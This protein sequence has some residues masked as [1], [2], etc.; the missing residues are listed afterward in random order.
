MQKLKNLVKKYFK[1][2]SFFYRYLRGK[3]FIAFILSVGVSFLDGLGLTMFIPLLQIVEDGGMANPDEMGQLGIFVKVIQGLGIPMT[4][5]GVLVIMIVFFSLKGV[6]T[7]LRS[8]Y[9]VILLQ[10]FNRKIRLNLLNL[11]N[12]LD[13]KRFILSDVGRIQNTMT[14]EV[15]R[16]ASAFANYFRTF[17][18][19]VM[20]LVYIGFAFM[21]D[22]QFAILVS[23]GGVLTNLLYNFIYKRTKGAS[24]ELTRY[25]SAF[26]GQVIQHVGHFK[27]LKA[28]GMVN[29]YGGK[30]NETIFNIE[31]SLRRI[32][33][34]N[35]IA[36]SAREPMLV[37]II[38]IVIFIQATFFG[39][40]IGVIL[41]SLLFFYRALSALMA[42][43]GHWNSYMAVS[44]SI[45]N[46]QDFQKH[47]EAGKEKVGKTAIKSFKKSINISDVSF[48][49]G[50]EQI[51]K[52]INLEVKHNESVAFVGESGSG[53]TT[54]INLIAG[55]LPE[56]EGHI[57][58]D[59][60]PLRELN[61]ETY[62]KRIGYV[63][64]DPVVFNDTIYNNVTFWAPPTPENLKR[65]ERS[66]KQA[67]LHVFLDELP[68]GKNTQ[69][70]NNGI[71]LSGGQKQRIS[72]ARE[73]FKEIDILIL[74]EATS[75]L[76]SETEKTI[77]KSIDALK[78][79]YT[80]LA[81]AHRLSTIRKA[82]RI[83]FMDKGK[84]LDVD[85][86]EGLVQ[87]Q[88]RFKKMV[89]LQEL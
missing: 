39:G 44:G 57:L 3:I 24:R 26:Q 30:L 8:I 31:K 80:I 72:I 43:Q 11:L 9:L 16:V 13:F 45:E 74:D 5:I 10:S 18:Q 82:D 68:E 14:G 54:L 35:A 52:N 66:V 47:L 86:F 78:G 70:G 27:Y 6:A 46:M 51:L 28:T 76:D 83:V 61:K 34:L 53:K 36:T 12:R 73:L 7:Y 58:I 49:Y 40:N 38:A 65:F 48:S 88:E 79:E 60:T 23:I 15:S 42:L 41:I 25:N 17:Q 75:A 87:K 89:E 33:S 1:D 4:L 64:Q 32:G 63:S 22:A 2:F 62:Q 77:Q 21:A 67:A 56:S 55:L 59:G 84:I 20:V 71:N 81:V 29:T 19:A 50:K 69:L 85:N 37:F